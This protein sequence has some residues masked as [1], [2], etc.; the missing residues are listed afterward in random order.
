MNE[1][2]ADGYWLECAGSPIFVT[3]QYPEYDDKDQVEI[4]NNFELTDYDSW[5]E[6]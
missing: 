3:Y 1:Y 2:Q 4:E 6:F 5:E